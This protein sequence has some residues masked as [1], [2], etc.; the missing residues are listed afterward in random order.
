MVIAPM[1]SPNIAL[2]L[3]TTLGDKDLLK[4]SIITNLSG[5]TISLSISVVI[6]FLWPYG[7]EAEELLS[8]TDVR[9]SSI[10][11]AIVSGAAGVLSLASG[12]SSA[13]VGVMMA[14]ALL[15]PA[16]TFGIMLGAGDESA[17]IGAFL[18]LVVNI[19]CVNLAAKLT[20]MM[21]GVA[22]RTWYE[23]KKV[24]EET[25]WYLFFWFI[26]LLALAIIIYYRGV[27]GV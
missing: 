27:T 1:L 13:L 22:P 10:I 8:R 12:I 6:G 20:F 24:K 3:A 11:I 5:V 17:A 14:A 16:V 4:Q 7:F 15:P 18:L 26:S 19:V 25:I 2:A 9:A 23:K 21:K